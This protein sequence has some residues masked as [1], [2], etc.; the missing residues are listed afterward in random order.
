[1]LVRA[2]KSGPESAPWVYRAEDTRRR[3]VQAVNNAGVS[4]LAR[5]PSTGRPS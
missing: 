2:G 3:W 5:E 4:G 1:V